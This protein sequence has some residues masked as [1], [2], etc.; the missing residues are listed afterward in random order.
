VILLI[1]GTGGV[2]IGI[3]YIWHRNAVRRRQDLEHQH[4]SI[5]RDLHDTLGADLA[6]LTAL[7]NANEI[8]DSREIVNAALAANRKFRSLLWIW[9]SD[10]IRLSDF[11]GEL[12]EYLHASLSDAQ[13][14]LTTTT[15][16]LPPNSFV[17]ATVAKSVLLIIN[18][19]LSN[20]IR[21]ASSTNV[22][23]DF[24][25]N[26]ASFTVKVVDNGI[27]FDASNLRRK[28]GIQNIQE[29]ASENGFHADVI[30]AEGVGTTV[31]ISF[32]VQLS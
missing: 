18:E 31:L 2:A 23:V 7:L 10:S 5:A 30:S 28:S 4:S 15:T 21:H 9:R 32:G 13:I 27:G 25:S 3:V 12:R 22:T 6:R 16:E 19:S 1:L 11:T 20:I 17:D 24:I 14:K 8:Q 26:R 29:R